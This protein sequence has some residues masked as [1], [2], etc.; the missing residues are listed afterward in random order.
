VKPLVHIVTAVWG[1][2]YAR[3][4]LE[5]LV[6]SLLT[7]RNL[8]AFVE[9]MD[10]SWR[11]YTL[12][13]ERRRFE[14][15]PGLD[16]LRKVLPVEI[17]EAALPPSGGQHHENIS[18][19]TRL[20]GLSIGHA[21][22]AGAA[23][24]FVSPDSLY[25]DGAFATIAELARS[26]KRA[27]MVPALRLVREDFIPEYEARRGASGGLAPRPLVALALRHL[28]PWTRALVWDGPE[29][30]NTPGALLWRVGDE[31]LLGRFFHLHPIFVNPEH[32]TERP[33]SGID[34][35]F[36]ARACPDRSR[37]AVIRDS[38]RFTAF[39][40]SSRD[41]VETW[42]QREPRSILTV[43]EWARTHTDAQ[44]RAFFRRP[45]VYR[46][47]PCSSPAW[48]RA[49]AAAS[50][51]ALLIRLAL[52]LDAPTAVRFFSR[53]RALAKQRA[54]EGWHETLSPAVTS[55]V[56]GVK[57]VFGIERPLL[58]PDRQS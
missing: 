39:E 26:G 51:T 33:R 13:G 1:E 4:F 35:D 25:G 37:V 28:H 47:G 57:G 52:A 14:G 10:A 12:E 53:Q 41:D 16:A 9:T 11:I 55:A 34:D 18:V 22:E 21:G 29:L 56:V 58:G 31:G 49:G 46:T 5:I 20:H 43:A 54:L 8:P 24:V 42:W 40:L 27:V 3:L 7:R 48:R 2:E 44:H 19:M 50:R 32:R 45:I 38:D 6:P 30:A 36:V 23:L 17:V 15:T